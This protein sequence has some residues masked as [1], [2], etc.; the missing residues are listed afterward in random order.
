MVPGYSSACERRGVTLIVPYLSGVSSLVKVWCMLR[1][2]TMSCCWPQPWPSHQAWL[3]S[4]TPG[5]WP[6]IPPAPWLTGL[7]NSHPDS[8]ADSHPTFLI[9]RPILAPTSPC[10]PWPPTATQA[11][12]SQ[13]PPRPSDST[14]TRALAPPTRTR[15]S[16]APWPP[17]TF[18]LGPCAHGP[19]VRLHRLG[20]F[21]SSQTADADGHSR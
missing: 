8:A 5:P 14:S 17:P 15:S 21:I 4:P 1:R 12:A 18:R 9:P 3:P 19:K 13:A 10:P 11:R 2:G 16:P 20:V 7:P 6:P